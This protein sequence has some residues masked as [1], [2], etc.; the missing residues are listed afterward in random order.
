MHESRSSLSHIFCS[1]LMPIS[2][3]HFLAT[4]LI[5]LPGL[6]GV[7]L[8]SWKPSSQVSLWTAISNDYHAST[9]YTAVWE[10]VHSI[11]KSPPSAW[12]VPSHVIQEDVQQ[13]ELFTSWES[14]DC[15]SGVLSLHYVLSCTLHVIAKTVPNISHNPPSGVS[16][17][18]RT[19]SI[20][21]FFLFKP[22]SRSELS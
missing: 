1:S 15:L 8:C 9:I 13:L 3:C 18:H 12:P 16:L 7:L 2:T 11:L 5:P 17:T 20:Y 22:V 14:E 19:Y 10:G 21:L 6:R 4:S